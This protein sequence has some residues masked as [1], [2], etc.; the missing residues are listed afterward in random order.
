MNQPAATNLFINTL[1]FVPSPNLGWKTL[2]LN[3][4]HLFPDNNVK[5]LILQ[6]KYNL[7]KSISSKAL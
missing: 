2:L 7:E 5:G 4:H 6:L 1:E 3:T